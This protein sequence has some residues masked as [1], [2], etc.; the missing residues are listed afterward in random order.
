MEEAAKETNRTQAA[1]ELQKK[2]A[3][4]LITSI[5][6]GVQ[7][8]SNP[9][10]TVPPKVKKSVTFAPEL[11]AT[12]TAEESHTGD[13][14]PATLRKSNRPTLLGAVDGG[15]QPM[16]MNVVERMPVGRSTAQSLQP[17]R[18][19]SD[20]ES[21]SDEEKERED[22][23]PFAEEPPGDSA[24]ESDATDQSLEDLDYA[25]HQ[26]EIAIEYYAKRG[27]IGQA[28]AQAMMSHSHVEDEEE[29][30]IPV[31][32]GVTEPQSKPSI[33]RFKASK[34]ASSYNSSL[35]SE[36]K[37]LDGSLLSASSA[38]A[39]QRS[40]RMGKLDSR[41]RLTGHSEDSESEP[42]NE[43]A[44][45]VLDL[46]KKGEVYNV[47]PDSNQ[48]LHPVPASPPK[49]EEQQVS[50]A[51]PPLNKPK[52]SKFKVDRSQAGPSKA[53]Q[54]QAKSI[55]TN[56]PISTN[57]TSPAV[58]TERRPPGIT[59]TNS[60]NTIPSI[61]PAVVDSPPFPRALAQDRN[62]RI[63]RTPPST[64]Q[65][66][67]VSFQP[68]SMPSPFS[69]IIDSPSFPPPKGTPKTKTSMQPPPSFT[70]PS[71]LDT[72]MPANQ[73][74]RPIRP[75]AVMSTAVREKASQPVVEN[76]VQMEGA[77]APKPKKVSRFLAERM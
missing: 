49:K 3:K 72:P 56:S 38:K 52:A 45:E 18:I 20:D 51:L 41:G 15:H 9:P 32:I 44:Q 76:D 57:L 50:V 34:L 64:Q 13:V 71:H 25:Q 11:A 5:D 1:K 69:M 46:L 66:M 21:N 31:D 23:A 60:T 74:R 40:I 67:V 2:M 19:D 30:E 6:G 53:S 70:P 42:E 54:H 8:N 27:I 77:K 17:N 24:S 33:S 39:L 12:K 7:E 73:A 61:T 29:R 59:S 62:T 47:G 75:P 22:D 63:S 4:G 26:R 58:G 43:A 37:S 10:H 28:A 65:P 16:R 36:T 35:P 55:F 14:F 48:V 68:P